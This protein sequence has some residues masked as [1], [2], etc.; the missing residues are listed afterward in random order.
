MTKNKL[1]IYSF[2]R[3]L[4]IKNKKII[5]KSLDKYFKKKLI[6]GTILIADEGINASISGTE[7][8]LLATIKLIKRTLNIRKLEI[9]M[10]KN[11][12]LPFNR[13]KVRLK[14]EIVSLGKGEIEVNKFTGKLIHPSDWNKLIH[15]KDIKVIDTRNIYEISIGKF[16]GAI[17]PQTISFREFP[18]KLENLGVTKNDKLAMYCTGG[19]RCEKAS[20]YLKLNGFK[21][22]FQLEGGILNYL[23][24]SKQKRKK[25]FWKGECFVFDDRVTINKKLERGDYYQCYG[26]RQPITKKDLKSKNYKKG[27]YCPYCFKKR[28]HEQKIRSL[29]R[30][31]Q[32]ENNER[33][34]QIN[35]F[36]KITLSDYYN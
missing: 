34:K 24:Y 30:Q 21:N 1:T 18:E 19:I 36:K 20:A 28:T 13:I 33:N 27:V 17:N 22:V 9:K 15:R 31:K 14:N 6:R 3:F 12:F 5:K 7:D 4:K 29:T 32:I 8:D 11:N 10:N 25:S 2:Y 26:C 16:K 35:S 23:D